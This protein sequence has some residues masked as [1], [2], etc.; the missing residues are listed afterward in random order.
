MAVIAKQSVDCKADTGAGV[1]MANLCTGTVGD[2]GRYV[3]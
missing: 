3:M 2:R 1:E